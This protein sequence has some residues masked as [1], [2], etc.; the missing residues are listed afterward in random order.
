[1]MGCLHDKTHILQRHHHIPAG[2]FSKIH[3]SQIKITGLFIGNGSGK[4]VF[5]ALE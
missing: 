1:M 5:I 3:G 4:S 2:I